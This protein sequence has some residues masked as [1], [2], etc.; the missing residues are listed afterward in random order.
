MLDPTWP[1][2]CYALVM[3]VLITLRDVAPDHPWLREAAP[4]ATF[5]SVFDEDTMRREGVDAEVCYGG[6]KLEV[7]LEVGQQ[8]RWVASASAGV[9]GY[10]ARLG[11]RDD[12]LLTTGAGAYDVPIAEH[13]F[14]LLLAVRRELG[15]SVRQQVT[16][17]WR[18][19]HGMFE[20]RDSTLGIVGLGSI[21][22][23]VARV[24]HHG[25][26]MRVLGHK[27]RPADL[28]AGVARL[29]YGRDG[30]L[31][32]LPSCDHLAVTA[33]LTHE[34][35]GLLDAEALDCLPAHAV[36]VNIGRGRV[37]DEPALL[38]RLRDGRLAGA[39]LDVTATEPLPADSPLW[40]L[41]NVILT[42]HNAG[43]SHRV[44][45][46]RL[47]VFCDQLRRYVAGEPLRNV[48]DREAGY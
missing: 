14:A 16:H 29:H 25:F 44:V 23:E 31:A 22:Q 35:R 41:P 30:L 12:V 38:E 39:G 26:G 7:L 34:T 21:G 42:A 28:P 13:V 43:T 48:V 47:R 45:E 18:G 33:A 1:V 2:V 5:V 11:S 40:D 27:R 19:H 6:S 4:E 37:I 3:K 24:A 20:L 36:I 9:E 10:L 32:M 46:R 8:L 17:E 15:R